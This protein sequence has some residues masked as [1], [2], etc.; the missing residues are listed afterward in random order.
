M[1]SLCRYMTALRHTKIDN[2]KDKNIISLI[3]LWNFKFLANFLCS[4]SLSIPLSI[5]SSFSLFLSISLSFY[6]SLSFF[7]FLS[8]SNSSSFYLSFSIPFSLSIPLS[9][10]F[11]S[12]FSNSLSIYLS[13]YTSSYFNSCFYL[14]LSLFLFFSSLSLSIETREFHKRLQ[15]SAPCVTTRFL[16]FLFWQFLNELLK[17]CL[18]LAEAIS[19]ENPENLLKNIYLLNT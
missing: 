17:E 1:S 15:F 18:L 12:S 4:L 10:S 5:Y 14:F 2:C 8:L 6:L 3:F 7:L 13:F 11:Y 9:L 16:S 19:S